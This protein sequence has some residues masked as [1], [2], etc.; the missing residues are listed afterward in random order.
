MILQLL[1]NGLITGGVYAVMAVGFALV[2]NTTRIFH[3]AF[4]LV[5][6]A[7]AYVCFVAL[8]NLHLSVLPSALLACLTSAILGLIVEMYIYRPLHRQNASLMVAMISSL[9]LYIAG[10][11]IL[12]ML[13]GSETRILLPNSPESYRVLGIVV[14]T[15]QLW[16]VV[17]S[18]SVLLLVMILL[19]FTRLGMAARAARDNPLLLGVTGVS[20]YQVRSLVFIVGSALTGLASVLFALDGGIQP[21][22]G[23]AMLLT[24]AAA[25]I[26]GGL[27]TFRGPVSG[28]IV[29][30]ALQGLLIAGLTAKWVDAIT[31][32]VLLLFLVLRPFGL[33]AGKQRLEEV[34]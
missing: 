12:S 28:G 30:G 3:V 16:Q 24:A 9:G 1:A 20:L 14:T 29:L 34:H 22:T 17:S 27:G 13:F 15:C 11:S 19:R 6:T 7:A 26:I 23:M 4:A 18:A 21:D 33:H 10:M 31:F 2:Y 25:A 32:C 8:T 5:Y